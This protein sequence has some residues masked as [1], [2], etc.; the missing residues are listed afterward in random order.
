MP[1][2]KSRTTNFVTNFYNLFPFKCL[3]SISYYIL[4]LL[5]TFGMHRANGCEL[6]FCVAFGTGGPLPLVPHP[7]PIRLW[8]AGYIQSQSPICTART[9]IGCFNFYAF[10]FCYVTLA[11]M[12]SMLLYWEIFLFRDNIVRWKKM[13]NRIIF[14]QVEMYGET[15]MLEWIQIAERY[16]I[17]CVCALEW[18]KLASIP[19][20]D[21]NKTFRFSFLFFFSLC[22]RVVEIV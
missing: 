6:V 13:H 19:Y 20:F 15:C 16:G 11:W 8:M 12:D 18:G 14:T 4:I 21:M 3:L 5:Y 9:H 17:W 22:R 10:R 2:H 1:I 7:P